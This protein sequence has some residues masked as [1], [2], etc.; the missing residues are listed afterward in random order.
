[1]AAQSACGQFGLS[2][3]DVPEG[4]VL[5]PY[6][7]TEE[8]MNRCTGL[9]ISSAFLVVLSGVLFPVRA[10]TRPTQQSVS[11]SAGLYAASGVG[12]NPY[13]E[14]A[15]NY[16]IWGGR[17]FVQASIGFGSLESKTLA[18]VSKAQLFA[19]DNLVT[20]GFGVA[21]DAMPSG[22]APFILFGVA[23][24]NQGG[25]TSFA[26]VIGLGKRIPLP[27]FLGSNSLGIRYDIRDQ[28]FSQ[29]LT[30]T[31]SFVVHNLAATI[32]IQV[33]F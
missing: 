3:N 31:S 23:G 29:H 7:Q 21:Y 19:K 9:Q 15:Y 20:Y 8:T 14:G 25:E 12:T 22:Y 2:G 27:G 30:T 33:Y 28:I 24:V 1:M 5:P 17:Y 26:G 13:Y 18:A 4:L 10:Q 16:Y 32:G 6:Y 11:L